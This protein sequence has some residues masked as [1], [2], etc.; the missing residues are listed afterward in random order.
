MNSNFTFEDAK[1]DVISYLSSQDEHYFHDQGLTKDMV[2]QNA[3]LIGLLSDEHLRCVSRY[4]C[5]REWS[6]K[7]ACD[8]D[9][10]IGFILESEKTTLSEKLSSLSHPSKNHSIKGKDFEPS[11]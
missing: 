8:S 4:G 11:I 6:C 10:G 2:L 9:P 5:E 3:N 7:D 1:N